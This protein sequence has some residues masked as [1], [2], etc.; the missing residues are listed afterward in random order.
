MSTSRP[1]P[2]R[3][4]AAPVTPVAI[5]RSVRFRALNAWPPSSCQTGIRLNRLIIAP[6]W[7]SA[8]Q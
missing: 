7:V 2:V 5:Q 8:A 1:S 6:V 4:S 3:S